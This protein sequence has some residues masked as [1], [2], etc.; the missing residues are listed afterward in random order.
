MRRNISIK[1]IDEDAIELLQELRETER[2]FIGAIV[3]DAIRWYYDEITDD[4]D[5]GSQ[6]CTTGTGNH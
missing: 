4:S 1:G 6:D 2:R 3:S 5:D